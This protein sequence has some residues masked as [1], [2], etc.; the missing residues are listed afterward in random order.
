LLCGADR[1]CGEAGADQKSASDPVDGTNG[2]A[3][4]RASRNCG[5][6]AMKNQMLYI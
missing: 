6:K 4:P 2:L 3:A 5:R 1:R